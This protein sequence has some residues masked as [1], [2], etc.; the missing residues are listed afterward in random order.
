MS[1]FSAASFTVLRGTPQ[2]PPGST[3]IPTEK[4][5]FR[6]ISNST[7]T[8]AVMS[9]LSCVSHHPA[10]RND[11]VFCQSLRKYW[12]YLME[13][14][15]QRNEK[16]HCM[17]KLASF[18][19][20]DRCIKVTCLEEIK[21]DWWLST[22]SCCCPVW[23]SVS[24]SFRWSQPA[25]WS[26]DCDPDTFPPWSDMCRRTTPV[27]FPLRPACCKRG[28]GT[29]NQVP[30]GQRRSLWRDLD[31]VFMMSYTSVCLYWFMVRSI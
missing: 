10:P 19:V 1:A 9:T 8:S 13:Y 24:W 30:Y 6:V 16:Y 18:T 27:R 26:A 3:T 23:E 11:V 28:R 25:R 12:T 21:H 5:W 31:E 2:P 7:A 22:W 29:L 4:L 20:R 14:E 17:V 15:K